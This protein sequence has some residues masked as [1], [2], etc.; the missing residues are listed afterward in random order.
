V[1]SNC[2]DSYQL[3]KRSGNWFTDW[4]TTHTHKYQWSRKSSFPFGKRSRLCSNAGTGICYEDR[5]WNRQRAATVFI[6]IYNHGFTSD[7]MPFTVPIKKIRNAITITHT[8]L[9]LSVSALKNSSVFPDHWKH[10]HIKNISSQS[11]KL[12]NCWHA[13]MHSKATKKKSD[14]EHHEPNASLIPI[15]HY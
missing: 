11:L 4:K 15:L 8:L 6:F 10:A 12:Q 13:F 9:P 7:C 2:K 3:H 14:T 5:E 1:T